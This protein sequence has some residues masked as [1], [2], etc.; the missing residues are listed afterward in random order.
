MIFPSILVKT[1]TNT[2]AKLDFVSECAIAQR[3]HAYNTGKRKTG[4]AGNQ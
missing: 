3:A 4:I 1:A 2:N